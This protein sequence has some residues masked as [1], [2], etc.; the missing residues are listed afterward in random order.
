MRMLGTGMLVLVL[1]VAGCAAAPRRFA[2]TLAG[3]GAPLTATLTRAGDAFAFA[4]G[5]GPL[6]LR[7]QVAADGTLSGSLNTQPPGKPAYMLAVAGRLAPGG[8]TLTYT[9]PRCT[10]TGELTPR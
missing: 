6:V 10:A 2:G 7:G 4:P 3:C 5:D 1:A 9:T 8:A